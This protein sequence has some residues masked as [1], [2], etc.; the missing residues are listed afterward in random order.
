[1]Y[2]EVLFDV[3]DVLDDYGRFLEY[4]FGFYHGTY[5]LAQFP[6]KYSVYSSFQKDKAS[7]YEFSIVF[8]KKVGNETVKDYYSG[9]GTIESYV[10]KYDRAPPIKHRSPNVS[11]KY[12]YLCNDD[13]NRCY[14][15]LANEKVVALSNFTPDPVNIGECTVDIY[16]AKLMC[17]PSPSAEFFGFETHATDNNPYD[18]KFDKTYIPFPESYA[19]KVGDSISN[20]EFKS[21]TERYL[22]NL[23][24]DKIQ[25]FP[26]FSGVWHIQVLTWGG[27][28]KENGYWFR[29][30]EVASQIAILEFDYHNR[31]WSLSIIG[32]FNRDKRVDFQ[33][34]LIFAELYNTSDV[35]A[36]FDKDGTVSFSDFLFFIENFKQ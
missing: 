26:I 14:R 17:P 28:H 27:S 3:S 18:K 4:H 30:G 10:S 5:D 2:G 20:L 8:Y 23:S 34:F 7:D 32:D 11:L 15:T 35:N 1:M 9:A 22:S 29:D 24:F 21:Y 13:T 6:L 33:D 25:E 19:L 31:D 16:N 12:Y 36:D